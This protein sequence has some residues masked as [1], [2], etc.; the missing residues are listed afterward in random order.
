VNVRVIA[1]IA[2]TNLRRLARDRLG[3]FFILVLPFL[4]ILL[5]GASGGGGQTVLGITGQPADE[6]VRLVVADLREGGRAEVREHAGTA[7]LEVAVRRRQV[8]AGLV[9][10]VEAA[11]GI[12]LLT[13]P[14]GDPRAAA[15]VQ[16]AI[17]RVDGELRPARVVGAALG[18]PAAALQRGEAPAVT[19]T[20]RLAVTEAAE[21]DLAQRSAVANLVLFV[22]ITS[23]VGSAALIETRQLGLTR[24]MLAGPVTTRTV[25]LGEGVT[26]YAIAV[27]QGAIIVIGASLLFGVDWVDP[28]GVVVVIALFSLVATG[29]ALLMGAIFSNAEQAAGVAVPAGIGLGMLGGCMWPLEITPTAMQVIGRLTPHAWALDALESVV[30]GRGLPL[31]PLL[32][33]AA[34]AA[35]LLAIAARALGQ[36]VR[37]G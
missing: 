30:G 37:A 10:P 26:R 23:L 35:T 2:R 21:W 24:R 5:F 33:L 8:D 6:A 14:A 34:V 12:V 4:I 15:V 3:L 31:A 29:A 9:L 16:D 7:E 11:E 20:S 13:D 25:L 36:R 27:G 17:R 19:V 18:V 1:Q 32:V 28:L 22:F